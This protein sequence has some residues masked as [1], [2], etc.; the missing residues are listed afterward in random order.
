MKKMHKKEGEKKKEIMGE[1]RGEGSNTEEIGRF[2]DP[3][4]IRRRGDSDRRIG[5]QNGEGDERS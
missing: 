5:E 4:E 2:R 3:A 1:E